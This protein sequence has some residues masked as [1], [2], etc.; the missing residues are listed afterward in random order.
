MFL[1]HCRCVPQSNNERAPEVNDIGKS[2]LEG[3]I[4]GVFPPGAFQLE[5]AFHMG[6]MGNLGRWPEVSEQTV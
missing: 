2:Y 5:F 1:Y 3:D 6:S 4:P